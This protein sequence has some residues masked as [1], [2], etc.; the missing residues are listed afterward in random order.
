MF[1]TAHPVK[2]SAPSVA[3]S[4]A[5][6]LAGILLLCWVSF[7]ASPLLPRDRRR[8]AQVALF[9]PAL[10]VPVRVPFQ[11]PP[12]PPPKLT[13]PQP[14]FE[15]PPPQ[16]SE[17]HFKPILDPPAAPFLDPARAPIPQPAPAPGLPRFAPPLLAL[18][19]G[20]FDSTQ[21]AEVVPP[22]RVAR[23]VAKAGGFAPPENA[24]SDIAPARLT[25][26]GGFG[27]ASV[28]PAPAVSKLSARPAATGATVSAQI[29]DKPTPSYTDEARRLDIEGEVLLEVAFQASGETKVLRVVRGLGHGLDESA[30]AAARRIHFRPA[31]RDGAAV[32]SSAVVHIIFQLAY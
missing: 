26:V 12:K 20:A 16:V 21:R 17:F 32:D 31:Q 22:P 19:V 6:H 7:T 8:L 13:P 14:R 24:G 11:P 3:A 18:K 15:A 1:Q 30:I 28:T 9:A 5:L 4:V 29:L 25:A 23:V 27:D 10:E 2:F